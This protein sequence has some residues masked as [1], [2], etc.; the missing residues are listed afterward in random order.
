M[1]LC[2]SES[3]FWMDIWM[4]SRCHTQWCVTSEMNSFTYGD[5]TCHANHNLCLEVTFYGQ[6]NIL[7][8]V[9]MDLDVSPWWKDTFYEEG[10]CALTY[11]MDLVEQT[12][13]NTDYHITQAQVQVNLAKKTTEILSSSSKCLAQYA[14][15]WWDWVFRGCVIESTH[16]IRRHPDPVLL[17]PMRSSLISQSHSL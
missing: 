11:T 17:C 5:L 16:H 10:T 3:N 6:I 14:Y 1:N 9:Q 7:R 12:I 15:T 2:L 4:P 13:L 8:R